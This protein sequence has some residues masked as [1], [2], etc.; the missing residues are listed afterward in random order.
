MRRKIANSEQNLRATIEY[1]E[2]IFLLALRKLVRI[3]LLTIDADL[4]SIRRI[5]REATL[6]AKDDLD[7]YNKDL[8]SSSPKNRDEQRIPCRLLGDRGRTDRE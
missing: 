5:S 7:R 4:R 8:L 1:E 2:A 3:K 6:L